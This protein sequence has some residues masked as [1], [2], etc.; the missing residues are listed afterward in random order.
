MEAKDPLGL[1]AKGAPRQRRIVLLMDAEHYSMIKLMS[2]ILDEEIEDYTIAAVL[3]QAESD[4]QQL[5][6]AIKQARSKRATEKERRSPSLRTASGLVGSRAD[7]E[8]R[9][10]SDG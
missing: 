2:G 6:G 7:A 10:A 8:T 9:T 1:T 3:R 5:K 4:S